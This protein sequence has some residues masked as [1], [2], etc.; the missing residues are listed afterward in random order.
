MVEDVSQ[1]PGLGEESSVEQT[2]Q[3]LVKGFTLLQNVQVNINNYAYSGTSLFKTND[4][5]L[6]RTLSVVP[7]TLKSIQNNL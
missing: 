3:D 5:S 1:L 6:I 7:T 4:T 2:T